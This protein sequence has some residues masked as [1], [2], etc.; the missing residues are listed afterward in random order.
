[1]PT[2]EPGWIY[3]IYEGD[4][5]GQKIETGT[6]IRLVTIPMCPDHLEHALL[7]EADCLRGRVIRAFFWIMR[8][9]KVREQ[10]MK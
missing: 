1:M 3:E 4:V 6:S 5:L 2:F 8:V 10:E 9:W 7:G